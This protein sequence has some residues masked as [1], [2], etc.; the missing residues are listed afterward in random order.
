[1]IF[2]KNFLALFVGVAVAQHHH[3]DPFANSGCDCDRFCRY[4]CAINAT[5]APVQLTFYR[6]TMHGVYDLSDK[7]TGDAAG[8][9]SFVLDKKNNAYYCRQNPNDF[10]CRNLAQFSGDDANSTDVILEMVVEVDGQWGPYLEC[11][12]LNASEPSGRWSCENGLSPAPPPGFPKQCTAAQYVTFDGYCVDTAPDHIMQGTQAACCDFIASQ[13]KGT[14][15][16]YNFFP[17]NTCALHK[18]YHYGQ[19]TKCGSDVFLALYDPPDPDKCEC[20]RMYKAVGRQNQTLH[21]GSFSIAG[22]LWFSQPSGGQCRGEQKVGDG[23]GC[24]YKVVGVPRVINATC[25]Y[26]TIDH[27]VEALNPTCFSKCPPHNVTTDCYLGCFSQTTGST[28][29]AKLVE[30]WH[31]A[32]ADQGCPQVPIY[33]DD[34]H[35]Y[36]A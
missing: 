4:E 28:A 2:Q 13:P 26:Q 17:N 10:M 15:A 20:E 25:M 22:G 16:A 31:T 8:D 21:G 1:M 24:T 36:L 18:Q 9:T 32:F 3:S 11:N 12:P 19:E 27:F 35:K 29:K 14:F 30:P 23:S 6:M 33:H 34:I 5:K 7:D